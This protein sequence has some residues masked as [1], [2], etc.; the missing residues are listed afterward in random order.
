MAID[1]KRV[2][3]LLAAIVEEGQ[4][5]VSTVPPGDDGEGWV[6]EQAGKRWGTKAVTLLRSI[7]GADG[8]HTLEAT[9]ALKTIH[10]GRE[11]KVLLG[12]VEGAL[13]AWKMG[14]VFDLQAQVRTAVEGDLIG[15]ADDLLEADYRRAAAVIAGA[16]LEER[17]RAIA[18]SWGVPVTGPKGKALTLE[19]LNVEL[20][21]AGAYDG[22]VQKKITHLGGIRNAAAH[23]GEFNVERQDVRRMIDDVTDLCD[24]LK[25]K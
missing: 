6:N 5:V 14:L 19:P 15:Q 17:L 3:A 8:V 16:V 24:R 20:C 9:E 7:F 25:G 23:G 18:P 13:D 10:R 22:I 21:K 11:A 4:S 1:P 2:E 12:V